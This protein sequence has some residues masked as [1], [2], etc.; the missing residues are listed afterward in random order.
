MATFQKVNGFTE[1]VAEKVHNLGTDALTIVLSNTAPASETPDPT[2]LTADAILSNV[3]QIAYTNLATSRVVGTP[4]SSEQASGV[5]KLVLPDM[6]LTASGA[7]ATF[8]YVYLYND[9]PTSPLDP[10]IGYWDYGGAGVTLSNLET[11]TI[12]FSAANGVLTIT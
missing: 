8:R 1:H 7:V 9:T 12:D 5:Y 4:T 6:I 3:T 2:V 10:L 11:F